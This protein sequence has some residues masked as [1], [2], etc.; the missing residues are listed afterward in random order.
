MR[1][2]LLFVAAVLVALPLCG[3]QPL[4]EFIAADPDRAAGVLHVYET[5][6]TYDTP[7]PRGYKPL[8][9]S[10]YGRHGSRY[11]LR[12]SVFEEPLKVLEA[13]REEG[14]LTDEGRRVEGAL[15]TLLDEHID[16]LGILTQVGSVQHQDIAA[17]MIG[18]YPQVFRQKDRPVVCAVSS[19]SQRCIQSMA[20]FCTVLKSVRPAL[21]VRYYTGPRFMQYVAH[22]YSNPNIDERSAQKADSLVLAGIADGFDRL[23]ANTFT[24]PARGRELAGWKFFQEVFSALAIAQ[25]LDAGVESATAVFLSTESTDGIS[26]SG[27]REAQA[28]LRSFFTASELAAFNRSENARL[29]AHWG[30]STEF[31]DSFVQNAGG[32]L[33]RD[34][35]DKADAALSGGDHAA[36]LRFGHDSYLT[37]LLFIIGV[38]GYEPRPMGQ[39]GESWPMA[40]Y[41]CMCSNLQMIFYRNRTGDVLVKLRRNESDVTIP[42]LETASGPFYSWSVLRPYL[43]GRIK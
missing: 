20:N 36:D 27:V 7:A 29:F 34:F 15:R 21:D 13:A 32:P 9:I 39:A 28:L 2:I 40:R 10:H 6:D 19:T 30:H 31:G 8:Y 5:F 43:L 1:R 41:M 42:G 18:N 23:Y 33:L 16:M 17:R 4:E 35:I 22:S 3:Q 25:D 12:T 24:D 11:Q 38:E 37:P 14:I 26:T